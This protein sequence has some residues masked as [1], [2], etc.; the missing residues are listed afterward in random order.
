MTEEIAS[1]FYRIE[2]PLPEIQLKSV[3]SYVVRD[4][5]RNL[6]IDTGMFNDE[7]FNATLAALG[8]LDVDLKRTDFFIT[9]CHGDHIGL[10]SRLIQAGSVVYI[11]ELEI[12]FI[13]KITNGA[14]LSEIETLLHMSGFPERDP[15]KILPPDVGHEYAS[16]VALPFVFVKD[17]DIIER[18]GYRFTCIKTP[19][20]SKGH[21]CLYE[22]DRKMLIAGDHILGS[23]T[24]GI[25]QRVDN[26]NP[27]EEYL[28]SLDRVYALD[29]DLILP[30]HR[31]LFRNAK[32]RIE[33]IREHHRQRNNEVLTILQEGSK[34]IYGVASQMS[35]NVDCDTWDSFPVI[36]SFFATE[37][38]FAHLKYLEDKG[39]VKRKTEGRLAIYSLCGTC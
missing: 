31:A 16:R 30:G 22:P 10:V 2:I 21:M 35:W 32:K 15:H 7:C 19:G 11:N 3:N 4:K 18:G 17:N 23:I 20:H 33:D 13:S 36:Q 14:L 9:H 25:Q 12:Q 5:E 37:E 26:E 8:K 1:N 24:P 39:E 38:A 34:N 27:L 28:S 6:I 29:I